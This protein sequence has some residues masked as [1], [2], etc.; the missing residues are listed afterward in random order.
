AAVGYVIHGGNVVGGGSTITQQLAKNAYLTLDQTLVRKFKELF[1]AIEIEK[2]YSKEE[3]LAMYLNKSYFGNGVWGVEDASKKYFGKTAADLSVEEAATLV[4][5]LKAPSNYNPIDHYD[6][7]ISRRNI[8]LQLMK[9]NEIL[10]EEELASA[11]QKELHL[12]DRYSSVDGYQYPYYHDAVTNE[13]VNKYG[14]EEEE[15]LNNGYKIY[16]SLNQTFQQQME[17]AYEGFSL[18]KNAEDGTVMQS[19]SIAL[20][21]KSG[22]VQAV[23][24]GRGEY[25]FR[26]FNRATQMKRQPGSVMKPLGVY[27]PALEAG[28]DL[29]DMLV[30]KKLSYGTDNYTHENLGNTY[31]ESGEVP[32]YEALARSLNAPTVWLLNEIGLNRG[33]NKVKRFGIPVEEGD[34]NLS[35]IALGGMTKGVSPLQIASAYS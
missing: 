8:V 18:F 5:M 23:I 33:I 27:T 16:T 11:K 17:K 10:T 34:K 32:M 25:T 7:P 21:P 29:D 2:H 24:G 12:Q 31:S 3:I 26:G 14:I 20:D 13:A 35:A 22:G 28:Y 30:D 1:L 4:G 6:R 9:D 19:A 15:L